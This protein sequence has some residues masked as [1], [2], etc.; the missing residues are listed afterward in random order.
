MNYQFTFDVLWKTTKYILFL[1]RELEVIIISESNDQEPTVRQVEVI[2]SID[3]ISPTVLGLIR[4]QA[5]AYYKRV[6]ELVDLEE[7]DIEINEEDLDNHYS[8]NGIVIPRMQ[9]CTTNYVF[10]T[11]ECDWDPEHGIEILLKE[12][13]PIECGEQDCLYLNAAWKSYIS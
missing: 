8:L 6:A 12:G 2:D 3:K 13:V 7:Y 10:L 1:E 5:K 4:E 11:G 9:D